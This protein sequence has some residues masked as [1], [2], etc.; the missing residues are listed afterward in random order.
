M[1]LRERLQEDLRTALRARD[2][3]RKSVIRLT[4]AALTNAEIEKGELDEGDIAAILQREANRRRDSIAEIKHYERHDLLG[5]EEAELEILEEYLPEL[6]S[7]EKIAEVARQVIG[8]VGATDAKQ[9]GAVMA[10]L[11]PQLKGRADGRLVNEVV[12]GL[13]SS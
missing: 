9:V 1:I 12:R 4:L 7:R 6:L 13:L 10:Q 5:D 8:Q 3:R 2:E 11:M